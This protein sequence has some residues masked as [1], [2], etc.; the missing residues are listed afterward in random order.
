[1]SS[2]WSKYFALASL[3]AAIT[4]LTWTD[5]SMNY[6]HGT[7]YIPVKPAPQ[8]KGVNWNGEPFDLV[9]LQGQIVLVFFGYTTCPDVCP[10]ALARL[11]MLKT[12]MESDERDNL[13]VV[14]I[15]VDPKRDSVERLGK[16][17]PYFDPSFFGVHMKPESLRKT[18]SAFDVVFRKSPST[19]GKATEANY[20]MDHTATIFV[21]DS[22]GMLRLTFPYDTRPEHMLK[23]IKLLVDEKG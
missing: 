9:Q 7:P 20:W 13:A 15:S 4:I 19:G 22:D 14:F 3:V 10:T 23:D 5:L 1:M 11:K 21:A 8:L 12:S 2:K 18:A 17:V 16:Y 6:N